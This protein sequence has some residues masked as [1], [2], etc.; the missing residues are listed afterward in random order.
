MEFGAEGEE[1]LRGLAEAGAFL[2]AYQEVLRRTPAPSPKDLAR[3]RKSFVDLTSTIE[4]MMD[5]LLTAMACVGTPSPSMRRWQ[6]DAPMTAFRCRV[7]SRSAATIPVLA[8]WSEV[9]ALLWST[10]LCA[11][12]RSDLGDFEARH[13]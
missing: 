1:L 13:A 11:V 10:E 9:E 3:T 7:P 2:E 6:E 4:A 5:D 8:E 12:S